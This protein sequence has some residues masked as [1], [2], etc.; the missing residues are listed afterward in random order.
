MFALRPQ[1]ALFPNSGLGR[2]LS[3]KVRFVVW[4]HLKT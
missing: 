3:E 4:I 2:T 1:R